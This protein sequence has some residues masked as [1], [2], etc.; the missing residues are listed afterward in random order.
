MVGGGHVT[1]DTTPK[2]DGEINDISVQPDGSV[3]FRG[4]IT[5]QT[6]IRAEGNIDCGSSLNTFNLSVGHVT[7]YLSCDFG[8]STTSISCTGLN[9]TGDI[10]AANVYA[11]NINSSSDR[12][13][14]EKFTPADSRAILKRV[15][16][17]PITS[18]NFK[19][20][21]ATRHIGPM[22]QDFYAAFNVGTVDRHI[23]VVDEGGVALAAIQGLNQAVEEKDARIKDLEG[24]LA[25][26]EA[27]L[28]R[29]TNQVG[30]GE[31]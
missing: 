21:A 4:K 7:S 25:K 6:D 31:K 16:G 8:L 17:L 30:N 2:A 15:A 23:G 29:L 19:G 28:D 12:N 13:L 24:R 3:N 26:M 27:K 11:S 5:T 9:S 22:A 1:M 10:S 20:D 18:W 14:K